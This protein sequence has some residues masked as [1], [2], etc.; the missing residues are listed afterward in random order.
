VHLDLEQPSVAAEHHA[1]VCIVG[2]GIAGL[3]LATRLARHG[4]DVHLLEA[5]GLEQEDRSQALYRAR[6]A[7]NAEEHL[8]V[9]QG[10]FRTFGGSSTQWGGQILPFTPDIFSPSPHLKNLA[11]PIAENEL[12]PYYDDIHAILGVDRLPFT[13]DLLP[14]LGHAPLP[15]SPDV[16][17]RFSK[18][19]P[20]PR[21]NLARTIGAEALANPKI[22]VVTHANTASLE[23]DPADSS[24]ITSARVLNYSGREFTFTA[25]RFIVAA[26]T[27]ESCRLLLCSPSVPNPYDLI[28]RYFHDHVSCHVARFHSPVRERITGFTG[29]FY[30]DGTMHSCKFEASDELREREGLLSVMAH[31]VVIEP[32]DSGTAA[33][34]NLM[35]SLQQ[36]RLKQALTENLAPM[37]R[38]LGDVVRLAYSLRFKKRR[39]ISKRATLYLNVDVEQQPDANNRITL[40]P[41]DKDSLGLP[42]T[43]VDWRIGEVEKRTALRYVEA[44]RRYL[45]SNGFDPGEW[46][47]GLAIGTL[48]R[49]VD[50]TH[51]MGGLRM[52][53]D[54]TA[55]VV[56]RNL[57]VHQLKNL[58]VASCAVF[59][60]GSS[61]NPTFT[62]MALSMR[63]A[64]QLAG[65]L[66]RQ[67]PDAASQ[68][69][70]TP[71]PQA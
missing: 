37:L 11:W 6:M 57:R 8:G 70:A 61:S 19:T 67:Q 47:P 63:L 10:R 68:A 51:A 55:S 56:D 20:F 32:E 71:A 31:V 14:A 59:P 38:G 42:V 46:D 34:R 13:G 7:P 27:I 39:A 21:R 45:A 15:S 48:P 66:T 28:G 60:A 5:G 36:G 23:A 3:T 44:I 18:W 35:R 65:E 43:V 53:D 12:T 62:M 41:T 26:G 2:G 52:G 64:D 50:T 9:N 33:I 1:T 4:I 16:R 25:D 29:P 58:Y 54:P 49:M 40:H 30:V 24:H 17:V 69:A 22:T